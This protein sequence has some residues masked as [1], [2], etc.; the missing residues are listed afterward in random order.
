MTT[1]DRMY[2]D[3][4]EELAYLRRGDSK[5]GS[6]RCKAVD[7]DGER[8]L[9]DYLHIYLPKWSSHLGASSREWK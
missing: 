1:S 8:C 7:F 9:K 2:Q 6:T 4:V 5:M 3:A